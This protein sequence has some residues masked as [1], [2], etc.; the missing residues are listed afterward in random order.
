MPW[1]IDPARIVTDAARELAA[2]FP[3]DLRSLVLYGSAAGADFRPDR[4]DINFAVILNAVTA[5]HLGRIAQW[6]YGWRARRV[7]VPLVMS[8][9]DVERSL[10]VFPLE[11]LDLKARHRVLAGDDFLAT[12]EIPPEA[13]RHQCER[14]AK[15]KLLR[16][17]A[18]YIEL[19]GSV[20]DRRMLMLD[21]RKTF[22]SVLRGLL[23]LR[24]VPWQGNG[25]AVAHAFEQAYGITLPVIASLG[26]AAPSDPIENQFDAYLVEVERLADVADREA[27]PVAA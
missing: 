8:R 12:L 25:A 7:S 1:R 19:A 14:E 23:H 13:V 26:G 9:T 18:L 4:S 6:W 17:R 24:G 5:T 10:D 16:L 20:H 21:S 3:D 22:I 27:R 11:F 2:L 15:G